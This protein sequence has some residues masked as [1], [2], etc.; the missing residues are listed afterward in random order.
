[1]AFR[2]FRILGRQAA[3]PLARARRAVVWDPA[4]TGQDIVELRAS[5]HSRTPL[6]PIVVPD[7]PSF[8][9]V[10]TGDAVDITRLPAPRL[11]HGDGGR[12]LN[13]FG[14]IVAG[15]P[16]CSWTNW[17]I[18]RIKVLDAKRMTGIIDPQQGISA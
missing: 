5:G 15:E 3:R 4:S 10:G 17:S 7:A 6:K 16:D 12:Y 18:A 14:C 1:M 13:T 2:G 11:H 8:Q 9:N